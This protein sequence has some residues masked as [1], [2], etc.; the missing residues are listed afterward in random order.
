MI[1]LKMDGKIFEV[2]VMLSYDDIN[3][4]NYSI[5]VAALIFSEMTSLQ[6]LYIT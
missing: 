4:K 3:M 5:M 2:K 1:L 6:H